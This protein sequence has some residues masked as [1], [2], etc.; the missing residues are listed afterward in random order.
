MR[1]HETSQPAALCLDL[2]LPQELLLSRGLKAGDVMQIFLEF[3]TSSDGVLDLQE[4]RAALDVMGCSLS[5]DKLRQVFEFFDT[6]GN[7]LLDAMEFC[8]VVFPGLS[9]DEIFRLVH[10]AGLD[11]KLAAAQ[12]AGSPES[13]RRARSGLPE[14]TAEQHT[15]A[16]QLIDAD[17]DAPPATGAPTVVALT[18]D[19]IAL[20]GGAMADLAT[21]LPPKMRARILQRQRSGQCTTDAVLSELKRVNSSFEI[22]EDVGRTSTVRTSSLRLSNGARSA[23]RSSLGRCS[24]ALARAS[25]NSCAWGGSA[26]EL[27]LTES[28]CGGGDAGGGG[29][30]SSRGSS[31]P[32]TM[33]SRDTRQARSGRIALRCQGGSPKGTGPHGPVSSVARAFGRMPSNSSSSNLHV[34]FVTLGTSAGLSEDSPSASRRSVDSDHGASFSRQCLGPSHVVAAAGWPAPRIASAWPRRHATSR[35]ASRSPSLP[36][37]CATQVGTAVQSILAPPRRQPL[38]RHDAKAGQAMSRG[39][40]VR[41]GSMAQHRALLGCLGGHGGH[42]DRSSVAPLRLCHTPPHCAARPLPARSSSHTQAELNRPQLG[43]CRPLLLH[44]TRGGA[45]AEY[46]LYEQRRRRED[47]CRVDA[48]CSCWVGRA[49]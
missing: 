16:L 4:F 47:H 42:D 29:G 14:L 43:G 39:S 41:V 45:R 28:A 1:M 30:G 44:R 23:R 12:D 22:V 38:Q 6:D 9:E 32:G 18:T 11:E 21:D 25:S 33:H 49:W 31:P 17:D 10:D 24:A 13:L 19:G 46:E 20:E 3:D 48:D 27:S 35:H 26:A 37:V 5:A 36:G 8:Q 7:M 34:G 40:L 15:E 2:R